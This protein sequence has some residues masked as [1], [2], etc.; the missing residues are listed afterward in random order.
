VVY[1]NDFPSL[2]ALP[3]ASVWTTF[4]QTFDFTSNHSRLFAFIRGWCFQN[5]VALGSVGGWLAC[6]CWFR[7]S[8]VHQFYDHLLARGRTAEGFFL[9]KNALV[10][11]GAVFGIL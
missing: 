2:I 3:D 11:G 7:A 4:N 9:G 10:G 8:S 6:V 5:V 1:I